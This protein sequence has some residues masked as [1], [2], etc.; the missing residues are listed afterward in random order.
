MLWQI[1]I[2]FL[3]YIKARQFNIDGLFVDIILTWVRSY[4]TTF[5]D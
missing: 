4:S 1:N 3:K 5:V 2:A